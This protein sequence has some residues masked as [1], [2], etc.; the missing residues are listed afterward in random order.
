MG[1]SRSRKV[2]D[3][4]WVQ[5]LNDHIANN[6]ADVVTAL[7]SIGLW[8]VSP[9]TDVGFKHALADDDRAIRFISSFSELLD[10]S[11]DP[12]C[13][14]L[15]EKRILKN[16][17][18]DFDGEEEE[19]RVDSIERIPESIGYTGEVNRQTRRRGEKNERSVLPEHPKIDSGFIVGLSDGEAYK[20]G[21]EMQVEDKGN[22][23]ARAV[24]YGSRIFR[25]RG[26]S[27]NEGGIRKV[28][29]LVLNKWGIT[30][31]PNKLVSIS[32]KDG[33]ECDKDVGGG[34][35]DRVC[36]CCVSIFLGQSI[37]IIGQIT[38]Y[39][40]RTYPEGSD[41]FNDNDQQEIRDLIGRAMRK[42][43]RVLSKQVMTFVQPERDVSHRGYRHL[44][45]E[46]KRLADRL[47]FFK[48]GH[49]MSDKDVRDLGDKDLKNDY[50][51]IR[52]QEENV[53]ENIDQISAIW[54]TINPNNA[55]ELLKA[56]NEIQDKD[57][58]IQTQNDRIT[59]LERQLA[60][61]QSKA[62]PSKKLEERRPKPS[63][64][65]QSGQK[66]KA[67]QQKAQGARVFP[68]NKKKQWRGK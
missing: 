6:A 18:V 31:A 15:D 57:E 65:Q 23:P 59:L 14:M 42:E 29:E 3:T 13:R 26:K 52:I 41:H 2:A 4:N 64:Q 38:D 11:P 56:R 55:I 39:I 53:M 27:G 25:Y 7:N 34:L 43:R 48:Y 68:K 30:N 62:V 19:R 66:E 37:D 49:L 44:T 20:M 63:L 8:H 9:C 50:Q 12:S 5:K 28:F 58:T 40:R 47:G 45:V 46:E 61:T 17:R 10:V 33:A 21:I 32:G 1:M 67:I 54:G 36:L 60:Q 24:D 22:M 16:R 35:V 51:C